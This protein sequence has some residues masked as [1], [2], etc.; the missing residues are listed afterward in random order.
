MKTENL[1]TSPC[2]ASRWQWGIAK[3]EYAV[4]K[5]SVHSTETGREALIDIEVED[6]SNVMNFLQGLNLLQG[7]SKLAQL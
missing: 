3:E 7:F 1:S 4:L 2:R 6:E 5:V